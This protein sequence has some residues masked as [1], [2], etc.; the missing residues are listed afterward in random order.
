VGALF[1]IPIWIKLANR[2]NNNRQ[3]YIISALFLAFASIPLTLFADYFILLIFIIIWGAGL[4]G[5]WAINRV[6]LSE[7][8]DEAVV[9]TGKR[10]E[11]IYTGI[12]MFFN[13][14]AIIVQVLIFVFVHSFTGFV[15]GAATQSELAQIGIRLHIGLIPMIVLLLGTLYFVRTYDLTPGKVEEIQNKLNILKL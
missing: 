2:K 6:I 12:M 3:I 5:F 13:R 7:A 14:L 15:E 9:N 4:G 1:A 10:E 8:V 11:G